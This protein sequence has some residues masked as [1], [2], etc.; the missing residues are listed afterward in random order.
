MSQDSFCA[1]CHS[2]RH[3]LAAGL[4]KDHIIPLNWQEF[5]WKPE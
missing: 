5:G 3:F 2:P 4:E 1:Y